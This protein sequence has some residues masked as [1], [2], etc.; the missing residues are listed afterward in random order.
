MDGKPCT[1]YAHTLFPGQSVCVL[2]TTASAK[3]DVGFPILYEDNDLI[4][5]DKPAGMLAVATDNEREETAY[6]TVTRYVKSKTASARVFVVHRLDRETSGI[7]LLAKN[8]RIKRALQDNWDE[9]AIRRGYIAVVEGKV[10]GAD[11]RIQSWLRQTRTLLV[12][13]S[14]R[15]DDGKLAITNYKTVRAAEAYSLLDISLETGRKNQIRVHMKDMG[16]PV[17]GDK[18]YGAATDPLGRLG[19]HASVL[20]VKHPFSG[21]ILRLEARMPD[22]FEKAF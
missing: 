5:I 11:G 21:E 19:L 15:K 20:I 3:Y 10:A 12:Y 18:K 2:K 8:E 1:N 9:V 16:H 14:S 17:A 13:S 7:M 4:V 22:V 6:H